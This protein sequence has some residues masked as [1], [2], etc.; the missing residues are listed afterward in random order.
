MRRSATSSW[1]R[2]SGTGIGL[3]ATGTGITGGAYLYGTGGALPAGGFMGNGTW[4]V[5]GGYYVGGA[6]GFA[7]A[8]GNPSLGIGTAPNPAI[9]LDLLAASSSGQARLRYGSGSGLLINQIA[10]GGKIYVLDQAASTLSFASNNGAD[11]LTI[12]SAGHVS[13]GRDN[14]S[15]RGGAQAEIYGSGGFIIRYD[16]GPGFQMAQG[17]SGGPMYLMNQPNQPIYFGTN[18]SWGSPQMTL[19]AGAQMGA[20]D[21]R[22]PWLGKPQSSRRHL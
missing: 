6:S 11:N 5:G 1:L 20:R 10:S 16:S 14:S 13:I 17:S 19:L 9:P 2:P 18:A 22:G 21:R 7:L 8:G 12:N 15:D 4:N 3:Q